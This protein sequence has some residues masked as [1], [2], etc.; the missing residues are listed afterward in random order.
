MKN[1]LHYLV[2]C[3]ILIIPILLWNVLFASSLPRGYAMEFFWRN[4][5]PYIGT[6]ENILRIVVLLLPLLM[7]LTIKSDSQKI[8]VAIF[9][10]GVLI[11]FSSWLVQIYFP[12]SAWSRSVF[13]FMAPAYTT[14]IWFIGIGL[15]GETLFVDI[16]YHPMIY[17][18]ISA[19]FVVFH[20]LHSYIIYTRLQ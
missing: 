6:V 19:V 14:M 3:F 16:P 10:I 11:Y 8:G 18:G 13:G 9:V 1:I 17:I 7:P 20:S 15:I 12:E 4:I 5:P 2:S